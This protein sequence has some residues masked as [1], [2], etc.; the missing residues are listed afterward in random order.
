MII[1]I[2][3]S[4]ICALPL[5]LLDKIPSIQITIPDGVFDWLLSMS[6]A[7]GYLLP[8]KA[9]M[10]ILVISFGISAFKIS[11]A[12]ILRVKSFIPTMGA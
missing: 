1:D 2:I 6:R 10:P 9:L 7:L 3:L 4:S 12:I 8:I 5:L 11:W